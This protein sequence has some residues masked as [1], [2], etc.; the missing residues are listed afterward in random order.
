ME[1]IVKDTYLLKLL[2]DCE[3]YMHYRRPAHR[4]RLTVLRSLDEEG[5]LTQSGL[6]GKM[7]VKAGSMSE[8]LRKMEED[9]LI[10][11]KRGE[12]DKRQ[13]Y[14]TITDAGRDK[15]LHIEEVRKE[16]AKDTFA[17]LNSEEKEQLYALL[18]KLLNDWKDKWEVEA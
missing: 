3:Y 16:K 18:G 13:V 8:L 6:I 17:S 14:V 5:P 1:I 2:N 10:Q 11:R 4:G 12:K 9:G 7:D 15:M